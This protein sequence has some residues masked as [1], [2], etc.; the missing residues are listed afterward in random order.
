M[1]TRSELELLVAFAAFDK[2][3]DMPR[4]SLSGSSRS[5]IGELLGALKPRRSPVPRLIVIQG[6]EDE[7]DLAA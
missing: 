1:H 2:V 3:A 4:P 6:A 5:F 7:K